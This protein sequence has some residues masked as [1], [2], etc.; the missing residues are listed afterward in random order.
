[1]KPVKK[2]LTIL[3][4]AVVLPFAVSIPGGVCVIFLSRSPWV[5]ML[6]PPVLITVLYLIFLKKIDTMLALKVNGICVC[7][8]VVVYTVLLTIAGG[9]TDG[10]LLQNA[11]L[12]IA[13]PFVPLFFL[14]VFQNVRLLFFAA[15]ALTYAAAF[16]VCFF[17]ERKWLRHQKRLLIPA[18]CILLCIG[19]CTG[20]YLNRPSKRY[21][22]H[23]FDY[24]H[25]W[26]STDF[27][28]YMVCSTH[29]KLAALDHEAALKISDPD[30]MPVMDGAEAC[31]PVYAAIA[32]AVYEDIDRIEEEAMAEAERKQDR[33]IL[34]Q[35]GRIVTF[36][37]TISGFNR[38]IMG[39]KFGTGKAD[40]FFGARPSK[41]QLE[42]AKEERI[43]L[44]ITQIG[45]EGFV[46]FTEKDNPVEN[47]TSSQI[48]DIYTGKITNWKEVGGKDQAII[49]FQRPANSGSQT[50]ME[51]FMGDVPLKAPMTYETVDA[52]A[53]VIHKVAQYADEAGAFGYSF[54]YFVE[55]L[56]QEKN[57]K[58][59]AVDGVFP[60]IENIENGSYP[61][62]TGLCLITREND[63][64]PNVRKMI[65]FILSKDGQELI[66]KTGYAGIE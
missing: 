5:G 15:A 42:E 30:E 14:L 4:Y 26:S 17:A 65:D 38:L 16:L 25:G 34:N 28:D 47:L 23:G 61:L 6:V 12:W 56:N 7:F 19:L 33:G 21:A 41:S 8:L 35:N 49:A 24:M 10:K 43:D 63:P 44:K 36:T 27:T 1:M 50:M 3:L 20:L 55:E 32:K 9:E 60:S 62:T 57:V 48:R 11:S 2:V 64:N 54:R 18:V 22:G 58:L 31:Y 13:F 46:F 39:E 59:I 45:R 40:L 66:R 51:Y 37:N 52:M 53:G 29:S